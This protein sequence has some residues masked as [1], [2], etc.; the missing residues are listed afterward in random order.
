MDRNMDTAQ[1]GHMQRHEDHGDMAVHSQHGQVGAPHAGSP[2]AL[3]LPC[4][5]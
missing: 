2:G 3:V 5:A 1:E 4:A